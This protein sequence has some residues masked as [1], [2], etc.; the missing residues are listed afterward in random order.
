MSEQPEL[1]GK[2]HA[3]QFH[4]YWTRLAPMKAALNMFAAIVLRDLPD[5]AHVLVVG[6][7]TGEEL[8]DLAD[9]FAG[10]R[11]TAVDPAGAMLDICRS[12]AHERG[13]DARCTFH[14]GFV[15]DLPGAPQFHAATSFLVSHFVT[16]R[17]ARRRFFADIAERLHPGGMLVSAD[18]AGE[19]G[20]AELQ[21]LLEQWWNMMRFAGFPEEG[22]QQRKSRLGDTVCVLAPDEVAAVIE[23]AGFGPATHFYQALMVHAWFATRP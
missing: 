16:D 3:A 18:I 15:A 5:D 6:A 4:E 22:V 7:G 14:E 8:L 21:P 17:E 1:F 11:F 2:K 10:W 19:W 13:L 23:A 9:R 12:R 20:S